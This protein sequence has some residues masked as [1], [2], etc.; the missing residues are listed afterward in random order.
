M[1]RSRAAREPPEGGALQQFQLVQPFVLGFLVADVFPNRRL[2]PAHGRYEV[3]PGPKV[4][5]DE[6]VALQAEALRL[7]TVVVGAFDDAQVGRV[8][9]LPAGERPLAILPV[10]GR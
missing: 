8:A 5:P 4:L 1:G 2:V 7:G 9:A 10:G 6:N 3:P